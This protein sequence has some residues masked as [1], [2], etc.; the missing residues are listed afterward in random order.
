M[1]TILI[2]AIFWMSGSGPPPENRYE[3]D[4]LGGAK[5]PSMPVPS[6]KMRRVLGAT[7]N[8]VILVL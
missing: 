5:V 1:P 6:Q 4:R 2:R 3:N 8:C 7:L